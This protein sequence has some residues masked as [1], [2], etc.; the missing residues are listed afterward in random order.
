MA[1]IMIN[2]LYRSFI[3][4]LLKYDIETGKIISDLAS[5]DVSNISYV[6]CY[7]KD[8]IYWSNGTPIT[9]AD[10]VST[11]TILKNTQTNPIISSLL[12]DTTIEQSDSVI[13]FTNTQEDINYLNIFFQPIAPKDL[14]DNLWEAQISSNFSWI[15]EVYSGQYV[16][17]NISQDQTIG[18]TK[19]ILEKNTEF[20]DN[21]ILIDQLVLKIFPKYSHIFKKQRKCKYF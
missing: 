10:I 7:L 18:I 9:T 17:K 13:I 5:C 3:E 4:C 12:Q 21:P 1:Q 6:E 8:D 11:Y 16:I 15:D 20:R 2:I 14:L 19:I